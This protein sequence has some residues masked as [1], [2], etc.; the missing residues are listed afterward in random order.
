MWIFLI[1]SAFS[2]AKAEMAVEYNMVTVQALRAWASPGKYLAL[3]GF[4]GTSETAFGRTGSAPLNLNN[5]YDVVVAG[6]SI[7]GIAAALQA[8]R[9][10]VSVLVV[11]PSEWI[12][13]QATAAG[14]STMDDL[15]RIR[16]GLYLEF[17]LK[18]KLYYDTM[19][20]SMG[21]CYWDPRS[22]AFE[23][24]VGQ[25]VLYEMLEEARTQSGKPLDI[26]LTSAVTG[27]ARDGSTVTGVTVQKRRG[28]KEEQEKK[29][30]ITCRVLIEATEYGDILP[31]VGA[32]YR[33][34][35]SVT[36][37]LNK[38]A[39]LQDITWVAIIR[40]YPG[41]I[42]PNLRVTTPLP[43]YEESKRNY[44]SYVS[45]DGVD[46]K[47]IYPVE[48]PVN[49]VSHNAYRGLPDSSTPWGYD[50]SADNWKYITK[51]GVN[52][53]NDYPGKVS[54]NEGR[55]LTV[56]YLENEKV[57]AQVEKEALIK[58]LHFI[59]YIQ[60]ELSEKWSVADD[61]YLNDEL[62][63]ALDLP[64]EW[65]EIARRMPPIPYV[66]ESRRVVGDYIL[67][68]AE[69]LRNSLSYRDGQ[70]S[71]EF[72]DAIAI[73]GYIL[74]LH[75]ANTDA[76]MEWSMEERAASATL[77]RP[78]GPFQVPLRVLLPKDIDGLIVAEKNL[79]MT[80]LAAGALRLQP[81]CMM[82]GQAAGALAAL[83]V[84]NGVTPRDLPPVKL[85]RALLEA[86]VVLSLCKYSDVPPEH[87]FYNAVQ[88]S[89]LYGF[90]NPQ[91][92]PHAPSYNIS[93]LD[94]PVLAMAIINGADKGFFGVE[95]MITRQEMT[96]MLNKARLAS[97]TSEGRE[98]TEDEWTERIHFITR[99]VFADAVVKA[100]GF[101][102]DNSVPRRFDISPEHRFFKAINTLDSLG[103]LNL[104]S[105][106]RDLHPARPITRGEA[107]EILI[108]AAT[109]R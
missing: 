58:T 71:H 8:S 105:A 24:S 89:S 63:V 72:K 51:S 18:M 14:V 65:R 83:S 6:G 92:P 21:T 57:R 104:Y 66:R 67:T 68:S 84:Q 7:S 101:S 30:E 60:N 1:F 81:I 88:L 35:N 86:G 76:D 34:G 98:L 54:E 69:L 75:G 25:R 47:G 91:D 53:G 48:L 31:L 55:G 103:I 33:V 56:E 61:E 70:T 73:G 11:E 37:F 19:E 17:I 29:T 4:R 85:Q 52:W 102:N 23:P 107:A 80:R 62:P 95:E 87:P 32:A 16:S 90:I 15:S 106:T 46:F 20:K 50:G 82:V 41:G 9:L 2:S 74:D 100:F 64:K 26:L 5:D 38:E 93:D 12:G 108:K 39:L 96:A 109:A 22:L 99:G 49:F 40:S 13:G 78:R 28:T 27:V 43:G 77:N 3:G 44:E 42:P 94:D 79:S 45:A 97:K 10:G 36:P 59:Y